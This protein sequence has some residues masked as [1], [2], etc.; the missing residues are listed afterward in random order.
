MLRDPPQE[1][2]LDL[3]RTWHYP[4]RG[5]EYVVFTCTSDLLAFPRL[6]QAF[7]YFLISRVHY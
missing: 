7:V 5:P 6:D 2:A 3:R 4:L 1:L